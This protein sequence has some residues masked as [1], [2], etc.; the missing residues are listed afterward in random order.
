MLFLLHGSLAQE[1]S[2]IEKASFSHAVHAN[3]N[4]SCQMCHLNSET[5]EAAADNLLPDAKTCLNC[6]ASKEQLSLPSHT[7]GRPDLLFSHKKHVSLGN[8]APAIN[9]AIDGGSYLGSVSPKLREQLSTENL[10]EAC[11]RG[12]NDDAESRSRLPAMADCLVC[13]PKIDPPFSCEHCH[14]TTT[15][16]KPPNHTRDFVDRHSSRLSNVDKLSCR[17][18]HGVGFRCMGCH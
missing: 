9:A 12:L 2:T 6:H 10:C 3:H 13:H 17:I 1:T 15:H 5:S 11:H 14:S 16:L 18:C 7:R 8:V 4:V